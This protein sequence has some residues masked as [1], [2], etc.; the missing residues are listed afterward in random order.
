MRQFV[1]FLCALFISVV[2]FGQAIT[3]TQPN[4]GEVLYACQQYQVKWNATG[5]SN[6]YNIDYSLNNGAIWTSVA[7]NLNITNGQY[8]W[9]V[10]YVQSSTCLVRVRDK[11]D[12]LKQDI[13]DAV[14]TI[15]IPVIVTSPNGGEVWGAG[16]Q[17]PITWNIQGTSL[18]FNLEYSVNGGSSWSTI[19]SNYATSSG[20]YNWTVPN[21]PSTNCLVRVTD[22][23]TSC[24]TDISNAPF[25]ITPAQPFLISPNGG[26]S[27]S[28]DCSA[29]ISWQ[30]STFYSP[31]R[32]EYSADSGITWTLI[33]SSTSNNGSYTWYVPQ[34]VSNKMLIKASNTANT[35]LYDISNA[36][37]SIGRPL[38]VITP[39][40][41]VVLN[42][43]DNYTVGFSRTTCISGTYTAYYS[44]D[45]GATWNYINSS[46]STNGVISFN[47]QVP[48]GISGNQC[49]VRAVHNSYSTIADT[50]DTYF[51][52]VP[53]NV[54]T[55]T[56]PNGGEVI[57]ALTGS[58][59]ITWT[60]TPDASGAY[61]VEYST[62]VEVAGV[63]W[64]PT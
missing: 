5:T 62:N 2:S 58:Q 41:G 29:T 14:F 61:N 23:T 43:C 10:P 17:K 47:W 8:L 52:I 33:T 35:A 18:S 25:T 57:P 34:I 6:Y 50:S 28:W 64:L 36:T 55:V 42:G 9:T 32:L 22:A 44:T 16:T 7:S 4:G 15:N 38:R 37:F 60:N 59:T 19:V 13:S 24:M 39:N 48:N 21:N 46:S 40:T 51:T 20:S 53:N 12:T 30:T 27:L 63:P 3:V 49:L 1:F 26:E 31:V 56:A 11:N 54:I 45:A